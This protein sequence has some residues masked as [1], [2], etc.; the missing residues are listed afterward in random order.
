MTNPLSAVETITNNVKSVKRIEDGQIII[1]RN[2][3]RYNALG[4]E[5][6]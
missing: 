2:G 5:I 4:T 3:V 6:R 1:Y